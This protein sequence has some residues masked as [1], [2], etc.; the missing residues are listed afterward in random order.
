MIDRSGFLKRTPKRTCSR[1]A[2]ARCVCAHNAGD[3]GDVLNP[4]PLPAALRV[5]AVN[6]T[7]DICYARNWS[8]AGRHPTAP[9]AGRVPLASPRPR[10]APRTGPVIDQQPN[11]PRFAPGRAGI[12]VLYPRPLP[13]RAWCAEN[14]PV[15][16]PAAEPAAL[17]PRPRWY[18]RA[19]PPAASGPRLVRREPPGD[20]PAAEPAALRPRPRWYRRALPP[21]ASGPRLVRR[22]PPGDRTSSRTGRA[23]PPAALV[24][25]RAQPPAASGPRLVRREPP[26]DRTSSRTGRASPPAALVS[27]CSTPGRFRAAL[28]AENRPGDRTSSRPLRQRWCAPGTGGGYLGT[29]LPQ[30]IA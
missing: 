24:I 11:R 16:E 19:L 18:R 3:A 25:E 2:A 29:T 27:T 10:C 23:S 21:A 22:E 30:K 17:R 13:G 15:I 6:V 1:F 20:R 8:P 14:R 9:A 26:G 12:D 5:R 4:R 28:C 7:R